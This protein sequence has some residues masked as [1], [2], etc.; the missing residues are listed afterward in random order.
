MSLWLSLP[1]SADAHCRQM[2]AVLSPAD[3]GD[4]HGMCRGVPDWCA[5][6]RRFEEHERP[7]PRLSADPKEPGAEAADGDR[8]EGLLQRSGRRRS[9]DRKG[10]LATPGVDGFMYPNEVELQWSILIV[11][12]PLITGLVAG[13]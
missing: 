7:R 1:R 4:G 8:G 3:E 5:S 10:R 9:V 6:D 13:A 12:Y 2:H 11:L